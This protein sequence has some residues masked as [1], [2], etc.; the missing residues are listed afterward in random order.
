[1]PNAPMRKNPRRDTP[2][3]KPQDDD[4]G[5]RMVSTGMG[6]D[7][8]TQHFKKTMIVN[9]EAPYFLG[10][11]PTNSNGVITGVQQRPISPY[12]PVFLPEIFK[13]TTLAN[14]AGEDRLGTLL[15]SPKPQAPNQ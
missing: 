5:P 6:E 13:R 9:P 4:F 8:P 12:Q 15:A 3:Q 1:M 2:S 14:P 11:L 7:E 10:F